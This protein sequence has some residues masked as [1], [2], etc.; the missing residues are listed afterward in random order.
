MAYIDSGTFWAIS[1]GIV[2]AITIVYNTLNKKIIQVTN[3]IEGMRIVLAKGSAE[4]A[5]A[6]EEDEKHR[7]SEIAEIYEWMSLTYKI[8]A[9]LQM[10]S[11]KKTQAKI[12]TLVKNHNYKKV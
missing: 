12:N 9:I 1:I 7:N 3:E 6:T 4:L 5:K 11:D 8:L 2:I 10:N